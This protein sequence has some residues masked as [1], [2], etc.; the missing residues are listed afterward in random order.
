MNLN[1]LPLLRCPETQQP[2]SM[3]DGALITSINQRIAAETLRNRAD[4]LIQQPIE[5]GLLRQDG[6][7]LFPIHGKLPILLIDEA[8]AL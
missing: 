8:I 4:R 3:A 5:G 1:L 2:L 6:K 7:L